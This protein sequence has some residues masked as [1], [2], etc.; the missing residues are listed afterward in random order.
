MAI[1]ANLDIN[2]GAR[3]KALRKGL[4]RASKSV[5]GFGSRIRSVAGNLKR[6]FIP[7]LTLARGAAAGLATAMA[8]VAKAAYGVYKATTRVKEL[9]VVADRIGITTNEMKLLSQTFR[10]AGAES[11]DVED[12]VNELSIKISEA[13]L[14]ASTAVEAFEDLGLSW[15]KMMRLSPVQ[16][17]KEVSRA[18]AKLDNQA[19]RA[20]IANDLFGDAGR[21]LLPL[22]KSGN[23]L[24]NEQAGLMQ[25]FNLELSATDLTS[26]ER[27]RQLFLKIRFVIEGLFEKIAIGISEPIEA[28]FMTIEQNMG[29]FGDF[30]KLAG[31]LATHFIRLAL[32][33]EPLVRILAKIAGFA[34]RIS[35][36]VFNTGG[37]GDMQK[38]F[39]ANLKA[40]RARKNTSPATATPQPVQVVRVSRESVKVQEQGNEILSDMLDTLIQ[41]LRGSQSPTPLTPAP[42]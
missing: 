34:D 7:N 28:L 15:K 5:G 1:I 13:Q 16:N 19:H 18:F 36:W 41:I 38:A 30:L 14:G 35:E 4:G 26:L 10:M 20:Q 32:T 11:D 6:K 8:G 12:L 27:A 40:I 39:D 42:L 21:R 33:A 31:T 22:L 17:F 2:L 37:G 25:K 23:V 24:I 9:A 3:T 29:S